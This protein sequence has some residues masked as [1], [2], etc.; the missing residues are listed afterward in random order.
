MTT[1][2]GA[3]S[4]I[5]LQESFM[6]NRPQAAV[7]CKIEEPSPTLQ[8]AGQTLRPRAGTG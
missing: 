1:L 4:R 2:S 5:N 7:G 8:Q 6:S 3:L